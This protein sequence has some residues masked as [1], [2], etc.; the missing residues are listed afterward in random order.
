[1]KIYVTLDDYADKAI[2]MLK[3]IA[4]ELV[5]RTSGDRPGEDELC[6]LVQEYDVLIIGIKEK[7]TPKVYSHANRLKILGTLSIGTDHIDQ[8]FFQ[9]EKIEVLNSALANVVSTAEH[10]IG[11]GL[12]LYK[13]ILEGHKVALEKGKLGDYPRDL[14]KKTIGV[15][16]AGNIGRKVIEFAS[17]FQMNILCYTFHPENHTDLQDVEFVSLDELFS[18]SHVITIHLPLTDESRNLID[19]SLIKLM[20]KDAILINTSRMDIVDNDALFNALEEKLIKGAAFD[21]DYTDDQLVR[22]K[23][24]PNVVVTPH[25]AGSTLD[26]NLRIDTDLAQSIIDILNK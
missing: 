3:P 22:L 13:R 1:M 2:E 9:D 26:S 20:G 19:S 17:V 14:Y 8:M 15:V 21:G 23:V 4:E 25:S 18:R 7:M 11:L 6:N 10:T 24:L 5:V 12:A 16:G